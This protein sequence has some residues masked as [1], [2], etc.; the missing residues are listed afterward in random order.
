MSGFFPEDYIDDIIDFIHALEMVYI[1]NLYPKFMAHTLK[2][3]RARRRVEEL[4]ERML[5]AH[6]PSLRVGETL[7]LSDTLTEMRRSSP[8]F[9]TDK[10]LFVDFMGLFLAGADTSSS[11]TFFMLYSLLKHPDV[12]AQVREEADQL[13]ANETPTANGLR[14][15]PV[16]YR[17][18]QEA[19]RLHPIVPVMV[20]TVANSFE[21]SGY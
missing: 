13:F 5:A 15:L 11:A 6:E 4:F 16:S 10:N 12:L 1:A 9:I 8:D 18:I 3:R 20:R 21:F 17:A 19:L 2:I 7:N 14:D